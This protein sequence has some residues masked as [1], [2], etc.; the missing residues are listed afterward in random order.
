MEEGDKEDISQDERN[1]SLMDESKKDEER[2]QRNAQ[3]NSDKGNRNRNRN[4]PEKDVRKEIECNF[5]EN[6]KFWKTNDCRYHHPEKYKDE[7]ANGRK[8]AK[9]GEKV[10]NKHES[11]KPC[12][13][14]KSCTDDDC[15]F[16]HNCVKSD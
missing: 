13:N 11:S 2:R 6:C 7:A 3:S 1:S 5:G 4:K 14:G 8:D 16:E 10:N 9:D 12:W 15:I